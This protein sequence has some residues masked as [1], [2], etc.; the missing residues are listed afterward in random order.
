MLHSLKQKIRMKAKIIEKISINYPVTAKTLETRMGK[1]KGAFDHYVA[2]IRPNKVLLEIFIGQDGIN[3][4]K[5]LRLAGMK[6]PI[7][8]KIL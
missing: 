1:G 2:K 5:F 3:Y 6:L 4:R 8:S 7:K